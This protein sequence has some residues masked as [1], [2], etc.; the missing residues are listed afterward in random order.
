MAETTKNGSPTARSASEQ[1][2][3]GDASDG[4]LGGRPAA[5]RQRAAR[6]GRRRTCKCRP[7]GADAEPRE[8]TWA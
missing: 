8:E 4:R 7:A 1:P 3:D 6:G 5:Q 2:P